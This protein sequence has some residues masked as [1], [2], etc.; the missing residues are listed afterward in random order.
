MESG[1]FLNAK[2]N[3]EVV[4]ASEVLIPLESGKFLNKV[5]EMTKAATIGLNPFGVR[6]VSK[7]RW[8]PWASVD[9]LS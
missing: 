9:C 7:P 2:R 4:S 1:K 8:A 5:I 6:E 3:K